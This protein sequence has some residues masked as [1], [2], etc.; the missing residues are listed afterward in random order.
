MLKTMLT[1]RKFSDNIDF[2]ATTK[3]IK[4]FQKKLLTVVGSSDKIRKS[5]ESGEVNMVFEN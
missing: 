1:E 3:V 5:L 2:V 4:N